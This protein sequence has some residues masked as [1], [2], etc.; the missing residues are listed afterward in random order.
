MKLG[1]ETRNHLRIGDHLIDGAVDYLVTN[2][3]EERRGKLVTVCIYKHPEK[4]WERHNIYAQP[5][6][7]YYG[8]EIV[9]CK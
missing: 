8:L 1:K 2:I 4:V 6:S 7:M 3:I 9:S 5:M